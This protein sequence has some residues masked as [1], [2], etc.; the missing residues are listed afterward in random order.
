MTIKYHFTASRWR[1]ASLAARSAAL[2]PL[3]SLE[4]TVGTATD[5]QV[6]HIGMAGFGRDHQG[7]A[8]AIVGGNR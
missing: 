7:G 1:T 6:D 4:C 8:A 5:Q 3:L 2:L